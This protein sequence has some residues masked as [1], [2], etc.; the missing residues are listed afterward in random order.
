M[1]RAF[2]KDGDFV[3]M[4]SHDWLTCAFMLQMYGAGFVTTVLTPMRGNDVALGHDDT[5]HCYAAML[6]V[7]D[8]FVANIIVLGVQPTSPYGLAF[9]ISASLCG[10]CQ[11]L[12]ADGERYAR[13]LYLTLGLRRVGLNRFLW[14]L[15]L[16]FMVLENAL[17]LIF[18]AGMT[19][20][21][22]GPS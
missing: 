2:L 15:E 3:S 5:L 6:Y 16:G 13:K 22:Q 1:F 7:F 17:F 21:I 11:F 8:H 10:L 9:C 19:S 4:T 20:E 12:R 14:A 18:L